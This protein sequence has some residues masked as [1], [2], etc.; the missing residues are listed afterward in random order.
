MP[1][2]MKIGI[3]TDKSIYRLGDEIDIQVDAVNLFGPPAVGRE[4]QVSCELRSR[5]PRRHCRRSL[6]GILIQ[7]SGAPSSSE[8]LDRILP[9]SFESQRIELGDSRNGPDG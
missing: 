8:A 7:H 3:T 6:S 1:D 2:R 5:L 4:V 9:N